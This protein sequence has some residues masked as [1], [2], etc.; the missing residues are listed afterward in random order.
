MGPLLFIFFI[1][2]LV[3]SCNIP[4]VHVKLFADDLKAYV[5]HDGSPSAIAALQAFVDSVTSWCSLNGL[6]LNTSKCVLMHVGPHNPCH[7][8]NVNGVPLAAS[9]NARD[10]GVIVSPSLTWSEHIRTITS[11]A[12]SRSF[13]LLRALHSKDPIFMQRMFD[14][15][16]RPLLE[17]ASP[18]TNTF[19]VGHINALESVQRQ[20]TRLTCNRYRIV[21]YQVFPMSS[22]LNT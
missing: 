1:A 19:R 12:R 13:L 16:V 11:K 5:I 18:V 14:V 7:V 17:F 2:D 9:I 21:S 8:Y 20:F 10:L 22:V 15:Y 6:S 3:T 4:G